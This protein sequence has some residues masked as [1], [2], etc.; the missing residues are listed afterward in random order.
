MGIVHVLDALRDT[1][2]LAMF[3]PGQ[4]PAWGAP[5]VSRG[6]GVFL[7][8]WIILPNPH[9]KVQQIWWILSDGDSR[10]GPSGRKNFGHHSFGGL[11]EIVAEAIIAQVMAVFLSQGERMIQAR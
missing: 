10:G 6:R 3:S 5:S 4:G 1:C 7:R 2:D 9:Q 8:W 11:Q